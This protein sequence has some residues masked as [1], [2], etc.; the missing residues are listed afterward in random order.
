MKTV[1]VG[2]GG[3]ALIQIANRSLS[4]TMGYII[5][6]PDGSLAIIDGGNYDTTEGE[7][8]YNEIMSR[9]GRVGLWIITHTHRDHLGALLYI[10]E[11]HP[12][13]TVERLC[14]KLADREWLKDKS[15]KEYNLPFLDKI[16]EKN[17]PILTPCENRLFEFGGLSYE[18]IYVPTDEEI[19]GYSE[20][21]PTSIVTKVHFP[22]RDVLF[23]ADLNIEA[24]PNFFSR[25]NPEGL[26]AD[27]CQMAHHG[28]KGVS[29][30]FYSYVKPKICLYPTPK[31]LWENNMHMSLD[32]KTRG[33]GPY[34]TL[35]TRRW[36]DE[37]GAVESYSQQFGDIRFI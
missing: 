18:F 8:L 24:E 29:Y 1:D 37:L 11:K 34:M 36:M 7:N 27:I 14:C 19:S 16:E 33:K 3:G 26:K 28:T 6:C 5:E 13:V 17:L 2:L 25:R 30:E 35:Q 23:L 9:G 31:W 15:D 22:L 32:P 20:I 4:L 12:D 10:L 21:N